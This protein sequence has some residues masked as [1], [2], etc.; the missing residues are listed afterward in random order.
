DPVTVRELFNC[1]TT[2]RSPRLPIQL[3]TPAQIAR[4]RRPALQP[5]H[6]V[7]A[8][9]LGNHLPYTRRGLAGNG[10]GSHRGDLPPVATR[11]APHV[12]RHAESTRPYG[13]SIHLH[14]VVQRAYRRS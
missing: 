13:G 8:R 5:A 14:K 3:S 2:Q 4:R 7:A 11:V 10:G 12:A 9:V 6:P 1:S